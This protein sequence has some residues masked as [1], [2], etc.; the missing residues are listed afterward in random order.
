MK[1]INIIENDD[2]SANVEVEITDEENN[3]LIERAVNDLLKEYIDRTASTEPHKVMSLGN[4]MYRLA[5]DCINEDHDITFDYEYDEEFNL[6]ELHFYMNLDYIT[7]CYYNDHRDNFIK[8]FFKKTWFRIKYTAIFLV[9]GHV[10][11][12][13]DIIFTNPD[14]IDSF[15]SALYKS[16]QWMQEHERNIKP[17]E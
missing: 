1:V 4:G 7:D 9:K 14:H 12:H 15:I 2:G 6:S 5:C 16:K 11:L 8:R 17:K 13:H 3:K 10:K